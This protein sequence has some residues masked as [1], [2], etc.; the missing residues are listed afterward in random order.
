[1]EAIAAHPAGLEDLVAGPGEDDGL[2][3]LRSLLDIA[4][5]LQ[6]I[7]ADA[8]G[9]LAEELGDVQHAELGG[10]AE[11]RR[12]VEPRDVQGGARPGRGDQLQV[13]QPAG[14]RVSQS[15]PRADRRY[16]SSGRD[17]CSPRPA[18]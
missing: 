4:G 6:D 7:R 16:R 14:G 2:A 17:S 13:E 9:G 1:M 18:R 12:K 3:Q 5:L 11:S 8:A 10:R 15:S